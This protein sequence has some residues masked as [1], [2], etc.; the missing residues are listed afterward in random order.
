MF[1][2][3]PIQKYKQ[4]Y[5]SVGHEQYSNK[6]ILKAKIDVQSKF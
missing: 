4:C 6:A 2:L 5:I 1:G 3:H